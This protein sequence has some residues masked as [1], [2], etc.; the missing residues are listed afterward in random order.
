MS[1]NVVLCLKVQKIEY[2]AVGRFPVLILRWCSERFILTRSSQKH[3]EIEGVKASP[4]VAA[5][6]TA[7]PKAF[8]S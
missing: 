8:V 4:F 5:V 3:K 2:E 6:I 7:P 1:G